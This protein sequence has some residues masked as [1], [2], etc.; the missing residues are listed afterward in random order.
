M[1]GCG[2]NKDEVKAGGSSVSQISQQTSEQNTTEESSEKP[3]DSSTPVVHFESGSLLQ[4][5]TARDQA[6]VS[7]I[8]QDP[9]YPINETNKQGESSLLIATHN[10]DIEIAKQLV[11]RGADVNQQDAI[12][13]SPYLYAGA[14]GKTEILSYIIEHATPD[15]NKVNRFGGNALIPAAEKGHLET[16][17]LLLAVGK[18]P[19]DFQNNFGYT[20]LI[21]AVA[22]RD[23][24]EVYQE[25]VKVLLENGADKNIRD[26]QGMTAG[27]Y[28]ARLGYTK[29][30]ELLNAY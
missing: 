21:E 10:N 27:D 23:G 25:I 12:S 16:V 15:L 13:D 24:S 17:K 6:R 8:L 22:L 29:M 7:Q 1:V 30:S 26:N 19:I 2:K 28:A 11:D 5:V 20:A 9:D 4:A 14:Q 18:E 3:I